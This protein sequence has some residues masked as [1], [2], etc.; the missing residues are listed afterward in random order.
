MTSLHL[1]DAPRR[2][3]VC[4]RCDYEESWPFKVWDKPKWLRLC[5]RCVRVFERKYTMEAK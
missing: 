2:D 3:A 1:T 5:M 4:P